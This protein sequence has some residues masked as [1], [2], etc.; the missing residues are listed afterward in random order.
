MPSPAGRRKVRANFSSEA[1]ADH[2]CVPRSYPLDEL[3][4]AT[5][6]L[7]LIYVDLR[8]CSRTEGKATL[9]EENPSS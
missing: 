5:L 3:S 1:L 4:E 2:M 6:S 7:A 8:V 9:G